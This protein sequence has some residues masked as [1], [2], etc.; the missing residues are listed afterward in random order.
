LAAEIFGCETTL[1]FEKFFEA[2]EPAVNLIDNSQNNSGSD[3][4]PS[5]LPK[6]ISEEPTE[7]NQDFQD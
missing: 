5:P 7:I 4:D 1:I 6:K 3:D 2:P